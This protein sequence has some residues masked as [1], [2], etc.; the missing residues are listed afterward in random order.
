MEV[1]LV[2]PTGRSVAGE[3]ICQAVNDKT[4]RVE[5]TAPAQEFSIAAGK[6]Q[7]LDFASAWQ[8]PKLWW[9]DEPNMYRLRTTVKLAG[10]PVDVKETLFG[11]REWTIDGI[12]LRLNGVKWQGFSEQSP[13]G[14]TPEALIAIMKDPRRNYGFFRTFSSHDGE[15]NSFGKEPEEFLTAMDRAGVLI[16]RTGYLDGEAIGY[17][18]A[19]LK[20]LAPN[21]YDHLAAWIKGERNHPSIMLWSVENELSFIN[22]RNMGQLDVWEPITTKA[23]EVVRKADPTRPMMVDGGGATRANTLPIHGDHYSTKA[24]WNYPQLA[25]EANAKSPCGNWTWDEKRP[26]FIGEELFAAGLN[27]A[28]AYF[29]GEGVFQGKAASR[30][31]VGKAMQVISQGYRWFGIAGCDFCQSPSDAD[32]SQYNGWAPCAV[33]VRQWDWTFG[34]GQK[35]TRTFGIFNS[36]RFAD[37]LTFTWTL[38]LDGKQ[39]ATQTTE[40]NVAPGESQK[41]D[42]QIALPQTSRRQDGELVLTLS[43]AGKEVFRDVKAV[44]VLPAGKPQGLTGLSEGEL[45]V[46]DPQG[47]TTALLKADGIPYTALE[48]LA[49]PPVAGKV[50]LL[51]KNALTPRDSTSGALSAYA[52]NG[53]RV[54]LLEQHNPLRYQGLNP[55]EIDAETNVG[56]VAFCED[57]SHPILRGLQDKDFFTWEPGEI[58]YRNAYVKPKRGAKSLLQCNESLT[59]SALVVIPVGPGVVTLCQT[60]VV[61]KAAANPAA[62]TLLLNLLDFSRNYKLDHV[63][64]AAA[65][66]PA[67]AKVLD[68]INVQ[69]VK[70]ADPLDALTKGKIAVVSAS[71]ANLKTLAANQARVRTFTQAGGHLILHGLTPDGLADYNA[72]VGFD[73]MI[74]P[75]R[76]ERVTLAP[77]RSPLTAGLGLADVQLYSSQRIFG[78]QEGNYVASDTFSFVVDLE[79]VAPFA[80]M[81]NGFHYNLVA[82]M[83]SADG[84]PYICNEPAEKSVYTFTLPKPQT[85][86]SWVW[87]GNVNYDRTR[88]VSMTVDGDEAGKLLFD[89]PEKSEPVTLEVNPPKTGTTFTIRHERHTDL[90]DKKQDGKMILGCDNIALVARRGADFHARVKPVLNIGAMVEYPQGPG[91]IVLCNLL[92]KDNEEV[93]VN[94]VKKR[95]VLATLL[96]NLKAPFAGK[97]VIAGANLDYVPIDLSKQANQFRSERGW[98]GGDPKF[99]FAALPIGKQTFAGVGFNVYEFATSPVPTAV[100]LGGPGVPRN[101]PER[102]AGIPVNRKADA[103]FFLHTARIDQ[104]RNDAERKENKR[105]ELAKYVIHYADGK[106]EELPL[107]L[108]IDIDSY[109]QSGVARALPGADRLDQQ[110]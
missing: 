108:E 18:P 23:V 8:A 14:D 80:K 41:F 48:N 51:G 107:G 39:V 70:A 34:S 45:F 63:S 22:A 65:V 30:A 12:H 13:G 36:T 4:G 98:F 35:A 87:V 50:W 3:L 90:P 11:F 76:R 99:T 31:A 15:V 9:P 102:V 29:G 55:A 110:V 69:Y 58:I 52:A 86:E 103:L 78:F 66:E 26:K 1:T 27:P 93:P 20:P 42:R 28:Y 5:M 54:L 25:Y 92:F 46:Y 62:R 84:W 33:L 37:P 95:A 6:E 88:Q 106:S 72:L 67:L 73:H 101:L 104:P 97:T 16:R 40:H 7:L 105:F 75:F 83:T 74:R 96:N 77:V 59:N 81:G 71:P 57:L 2:N 60:L 64:M 53:G 10:K 79:D 109:K 21:W 24:F 68:G 89:V 91:G 38:S 17:M 94:A 47:S 56:R 19:V 100:M 85:I 32:G 44:S 49:P 61:E 43:A 82:G